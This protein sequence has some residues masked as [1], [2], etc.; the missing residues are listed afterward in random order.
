[1][2]WNP[3][4]EWNLN[5]WSVKIPFTVPAVGGPAPVP[6][7]LEPAVDPV[8]VPVVG[9][10]GVELA[11]VHVVEHDEVVALVEGDV[12][13]LVV[14]HVEH[15][16]VVGVD[17]E[18]VEVPADPLHGTVEGPAP[19]L[20]DLGRAGQDVHTLVVLR[21]H[22]DMGVVEGPVVVAVHVLPGRAAV[23]G[24]VHPRAQLGHVVEGRI[25][26]GWAGTRAPRWP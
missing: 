24:A 22:P 18:G 16:R 6:V 23:L 10:H 21:V 9:R 17:P 5:Q 3:S 14:P 26:P 7:V 12:G 2:V 4:P 20:G 15:V 8:G 1:M 11:D 13:S 25:L 19:V